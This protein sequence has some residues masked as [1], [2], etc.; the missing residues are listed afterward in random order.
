MTTI[1]IYLGI[2]LK[3]IFRKLKIIGL[4]IEKYMSISTA[5]F[6]QFKTVLYKQCKFRY[7]SPLRGSK[8]VC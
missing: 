1:C 3:Y 4:E 7:F 8:S 2:E 5:N 6:K